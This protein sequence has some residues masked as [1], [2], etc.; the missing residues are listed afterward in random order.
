[1]IVKYWGVRGS[2]PCPGPSTLRYGGET[3]CVSVEIGNNLIVLDAGTGIKKLGQYAAA[4]S[5]DIYCLISH[6]HMDHIRGFP[7]FD[8]LYQTDRTVTLIPL[9]LDGT[10]H[11]PTVIMDG[12]YFPR[13]WE[14]LPANIVMADIA[15]DDYFGRLGFEVNTFPVNHPGDAVGFS[16]ESE[17]KKFVHV[18]DNEIDR[19][20]DKFS[21]LVQAIDNADV[22]SH[23]AQWVNDDL[24][25]KEGWG[26]SS[27]TELCDLAVELEIKN[28]VLF[29]HDPDRTDDE[30]DVIGRSATERL[31]ASGI[32]CSVAFEGMNITI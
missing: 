25:M 29:H 26:H 14:D 31:H 13:K 3:A 15:A 28:L 5:M 8:P 9:V 10:P 18:P 4:T 20:S 19:T 1:M 11:Y 24:P 21:I 2:I 17:A 23:D 30:L 32:N 22:L 12:V 27:V 6:L 7:F 16:I